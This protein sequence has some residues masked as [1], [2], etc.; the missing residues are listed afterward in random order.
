MN[1][2]DRSPAVSAL[3]MGLAPVFLFVAAMAVGM[4]G[5]DRLIAGRTP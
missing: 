5:H 2:I 4:I 1:G 3:S